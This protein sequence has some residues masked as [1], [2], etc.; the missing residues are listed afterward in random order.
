MDL[1]R[2]V[3]G[4]ILKVGGDLQGECCCGG[5]PPCVGGDC[6]GFNVP[7]VCPSVKVTLF[8]ADYAGGNVTWVG[9][10]WTQ[11]EVQAGVGKYACPTRYRIKHQASPTTWSTISEAHEVWQAGELILN[12]SYMRGASVGGGG[13]WGDIRESVRVIGLIDYIHWRFNPNPYVVSSNLGLG[14]IS[15]NS[16][17]VPTYDDYRVEGVMFNSVILGGILYTWEKGNDWP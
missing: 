1:R 6:L 3:G 5:A 2:T 7:V 4:A 10:T 14:L 13:V 17:G 8:D 11:A 16:P 12:R 9:Q 15:V